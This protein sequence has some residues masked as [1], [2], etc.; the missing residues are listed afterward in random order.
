MSG[1]DMEKARNVLRVPGG[2][3]VEIEIAVGRKGD[4][5]HLP[6]G[7]LKREHPSGRSPVDDFVVHGFLPE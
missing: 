4:G 6:P 3:A 2:F 5:A 1:F 7:L